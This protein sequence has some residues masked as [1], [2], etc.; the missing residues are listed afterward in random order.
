[1]IRFGLLA[2]I[3]TTTVAIATPVVTGGL[4][5]ATPG[6]SVPLSITEAVMQIL[7][8]AG[9]AGVFGMYQWRERV[10]VQAELKTDREQQNVDRKEAKH[11]ADEEKRELVMRIRGL[12]EQHAKE[13]SENT[14][15]VTEALTK[16]TGAFESFKQ[17]FHDRPCQHAE[18][19]KE[20][21]SIAAQFRDAAHVVG[22]MKEEA[23]QILEAKG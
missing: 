8:T 18:A 15:C 6:G 12:E 16:N 5:S 3:A 4:S 2:L 17:S 23:Q 21:A 14:R 20:M 1:M 7:S 11:E 9:I 19:C 13:A 22:R 10:A